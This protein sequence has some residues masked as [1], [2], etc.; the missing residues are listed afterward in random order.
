[1]I[2]I[3]MRYFSRYEKYFPRLFKISEIF[4]RYFFQSLLKITEIF[5]IEKVSTPGPCVLYGRCIRQ[6]WTE[7][8]ECEWM[9]INVKGDR[10]WKVVNGNDG[11]IY[12]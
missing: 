9:W 3:L 7:V 1:M 4:M 5:V 8:N 6:M 12:L 2:E 10:D 11:I